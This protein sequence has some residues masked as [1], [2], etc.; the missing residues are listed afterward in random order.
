VEFAR[1][2]TFSEGAVFDY[3]GNFYFSHG[4]Y[5]TRIA[6]DGSS[7]L[8]A[9]MSRPNGHKVLPDSTHLVCAAGSVL[10]LSAVGEIIGAASSECDGK[11]LRAPNDLT[12]NRQG[13]F[14]FT[15][16]GGSR[17]APIGTVHYV[18]HGGKTHLVA[19]GMWVPNGL[20]LSLDGKTLYVAETLPNRIVKFP[21]LPDGK[22]EAPE[23]FVVLPSRP[24]HQ[25]EPDGLAIDAKGNV[26]AAHLGMGAIQVISPD[27]VL[28]ASL[29]AGNYDASNL[30]FGGPSLNELYITGSIGH[31]SKAPGRVFR[32]DLP[33]VAGVSSLLPRKRVSGA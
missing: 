28:L 14:Y 32:L 25:P 8:W 3:E 27:G 29:P 12:L 20:V 13:G 24:G 19:G 1:S 15:D 10:H 22:L 6:L 17:E 31:R 30:V 9:G 21:V 4:E 23:V 5:V 33:D 18:D 7:S 11:P 2:E 16:P 26:Y